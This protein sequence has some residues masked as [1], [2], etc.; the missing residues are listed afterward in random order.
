MN[1]LQHPFNIHFAL[2]LVSTET[3]KT[4]A[5]TKL[6]LCHSKV[7]VLQTLN[8]IQLVHQHDKKELFHE[9][10]VHCV[11]RNVSK[12]PSYISAMKF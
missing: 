12:Y 8:N 11:M 9:N 10:L 7:S 4:V 6:V 3:I 2:N 5:H 1:D